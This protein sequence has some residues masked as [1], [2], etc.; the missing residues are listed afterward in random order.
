MCR[1][2]SRLAV[3]VV[4][5]QRPDL[6]VVVVNG[7]VGVVTGAGSPYSIAS[8][9]DN[10]G[11][12]KGSSARDRYSRALR[13][14]RLPALL[15]RSRE[16]RA[17]RFGGQTR[18]LGFLTR[19][20][21]LLLGLFGGL[22]LPLGFGGVILGLLSLFLG[23]LGFFP[24]LLGFFLGR[25]ARLRLPLKRLLRSFEVGLQLCN[26]LVVTPAAA[27]PCGYQDD[28]KKNG[29]REPSL[30]DYSSSTG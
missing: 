30:H 2:A 5:D 13:S 20:L 11:S 1:I 19:L 27:R 18:R 4:V 15:G 3:C 21:G 12:S 7:P 26:P 28:A 16:P 9:R 6:P 17:L 8:I 10:G 23:L 22:A 24:R 29:Q 25:L 14:I